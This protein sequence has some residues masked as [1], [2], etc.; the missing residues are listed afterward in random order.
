MQSHDF[1]C[2]TLIGFLQRDVDFLTLSR[3]E[4]YLVIM[5]TDSPL[6]GLVALRTYG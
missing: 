1:L 3:W 5:Y 6:Y 2:L 4:N